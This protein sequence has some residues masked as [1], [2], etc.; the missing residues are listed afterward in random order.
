MSLVIGLT[1]GIGSGKTSTAKFFT[2]VGVSVIDTDTIAHELTQPQGVAIPNI[3][4]SFG[5]N[6]ITA[7]GELD[8]KKMRSLIF[9]NSASKRQL[10]EI[11]HPL[12][13]IEVIRLITIAFSPYIIIV[14]PLLLETG[15]YREIVQRILV[16][17]CNEE[18]Q[19]ARA[20]LR[21]G[22]NEQEV[23]AI[24]AT[25]ISRQARLKQANDVIVNNADMPH[26]QRQVEILHCKYLGLLNE[27]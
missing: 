14:V 10:E 11:I 19:V 8:R 6:F 17:D 2:T 23:H 21:S 20:I 22:L 25:Q 13:R 5:D 24:M 3:Q 1:G 7:D 27:V 4:K 9:A 15:S 12:I 16:V 18:C 26:L